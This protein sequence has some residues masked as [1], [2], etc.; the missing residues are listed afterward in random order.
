MF[1]PVDNK[2][3]AISSLEH[4][5]LEQCNG[6]HPLDEIVHI[7]ERDYGQ[8]ENDTITHMSA[9]LDKMHRAGI[10]AWKNEKINYEKNF[11]APS[12]VFWDITGKC[13]LHCRHC[14]NVESQLHNREMEAGEIKRILEEMSVFGVES[15]NFSGG[16]PLLRRDFLEIAAHAGNLGFKSVGVATNGT[17]IDRRIAKR[18]KEASL[19]VQVSIDGDIAEIHDTMR[20]VRGAFDR[21]ISGIKLL[22]EEGNCISVCTTST[23]L[24]VDRIPNIIELMQNLGIENYR[25]QGIIPIGRGKANIKELGLSPN[26]MRNLVEYLERK[27]IPILSFGFTLKAPPIAPVDYCESG[28]CSAATS[29]CSITPEGIVVPC[30]YFWGMRGESLRDNTFQWIWENSKL[31]N[32]FRSILLKDI[33]GPCLECRWLQICHGGCKA[34]NYA[35]GD[36]F[37]S[38]LNC[39]VAEEIGQ[40]GLRKV[41]PFPLLS[42]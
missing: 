15:V 7:V 30:T 35:N 4:R 23:K 34:E 29:S 3:Y 2:E 12:I 33:K 25:V 8:I 38:N 9:F 40:V 32:Y 5:I 10:I 1:N 20:G 36:I 24:N 42:P 13:N 16:E 26:R 28:A 31:L 19:E 21:A 41:N 11:P 37:D 18:L 22:Q 39:W 6:V 17:L 27:N 14:Y